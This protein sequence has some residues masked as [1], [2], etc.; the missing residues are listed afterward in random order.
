MFSMLLNLVW[1]DKIF[2]TDWQVKFFDTAA[3][4]EEEEDEE[5]LI[6]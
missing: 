5:E 2:K 4:L 1:S 3:K 6:E